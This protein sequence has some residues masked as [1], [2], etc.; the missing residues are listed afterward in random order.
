MLINVNVENLEIIS[1]N[2]EDS[3]TY[4]KINWIIDGL[5]GR[6]II[7]KIPSNIIVFEMRKKTGKRVNNIRF[8]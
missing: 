1:N 2:L 3:L 7:D 4:Y 8:L 6:K 5:L